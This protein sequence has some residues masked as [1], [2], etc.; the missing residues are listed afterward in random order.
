M[1]FY[2]FILVAKFCGLFFKRWAGTGSKPLT[3]VVLGIYGGTICGIIISLGFFVFFIGITL[4][5]YV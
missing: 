5:G 4:T 3:G 1:F 2:C